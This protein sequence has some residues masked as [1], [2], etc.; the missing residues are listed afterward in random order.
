MSLARPADNAPCPCGSGAGYAEC[1]GPIHD[2][3]AA[4]TALQLMRSR[5]SAFALE[6]A[7][8]LLRTWHPDT[9][10]P[11]VDFDQGFVWKRLQIVDTVRGEA[12]DDAGIVEFRAIYRGPEGAGM[13][14]ERSTFLRVDGRWLY[15]EGAVFED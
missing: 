10:P 3:E 8:H 5:F 12:G 14:H 1:C 11:R 15:L 6:L 4:G 7:G 13:I 2:G 9:R